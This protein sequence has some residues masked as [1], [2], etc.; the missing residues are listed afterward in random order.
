MGITL[1]PII[2]AAVPTR[3]FFLS[4]DGDH[5]LSGRLGGHD[6]RVDVLEL[7]VAIWK[8]HA[9]VRLA[10]ELAQVFELLS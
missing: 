6:N 10:I 5:R 3:S 2:A 9:F 1:G 4:V 7:C 8:A